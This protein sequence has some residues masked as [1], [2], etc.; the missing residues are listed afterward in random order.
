M[1]NL[2][3]DLG[4][5]ALQ[6]EVSDVLRRFRQQAPAMLNDEIRS[7][8]ISEMDFGVREEYLLDLILHE[9]VSSVVH[10]LTTSRGT[11]RSESEAQSSAIAEEP[12]TR[13]SSTSRSDTVPNSPNEHAESEHPLLDSRVQ[14]PQSLEPSV[15]HHQASD[16]AFPSRDEMQ[17]QTLPGQRP[18]YP[19][20]SDL[21]LQSFAPFDN[22]EWLNHGG[23]LEPLLGN[24][25]PSSAG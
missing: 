15:S 12:D 22:F 17:L 1:T 25:L 24:G 6:A 11:G 9:A 14:I 16:Y 10:H 7:R 19:S 18:L 23:I 21:N 4:D 13:I 3:I 2:H 8:L 20:T 5:D